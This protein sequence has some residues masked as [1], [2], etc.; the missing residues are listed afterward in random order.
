MKLKII[1]GYNSNLIEE[2][3]NKFHINY[4]V[5][6][7]QT[8]TEVIQDKTRGNLLMFIVFIFYTEKHLDNMIEDL[9]FTNRTY[10]ALKRAGINT[11]DDLK[12]AMCSGDIKRVRN[13]GSV[14]LVEIET[15]L[16]EM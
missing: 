5:K 13:L 12:D 15:K 4:N 10:N 3:V 2:E 8:H 6:E 7:I 11:I 14:S 9:L 16:K 1:K